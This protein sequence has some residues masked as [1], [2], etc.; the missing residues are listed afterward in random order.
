MT[1][2]QK[3]REIGLSLSKAMS[4]TGVLW[5]KWVGDKTYILYIDNFICPI[6]NVPLFG[7]IKVQNSGSGWEGTLEYAIVES[8]GV[9]VRGETL[10][11]TSQKT[12][13]DAALACVEMFRN[14]CVISKD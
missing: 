10:V 1:A 8:H 7:E 11:C 2:E 9:E 5:H 4:A 3:F 14:G 12:R 6:H 13:F